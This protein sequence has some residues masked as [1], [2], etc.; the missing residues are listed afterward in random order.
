MTEQSPYTALLLHNESEI[1]C[2]LQFSHLLSAALQ[3]GLSS[4][5]SVP[6]IGRL[7]LQISVW[8]LENLLELKNLF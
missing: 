5:N 3:N 6:Y 2:K 4:K 8:V 1:S 7:Y